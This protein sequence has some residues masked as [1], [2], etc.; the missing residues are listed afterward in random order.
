M[1]EDRLGER[2]LT[3]SKFGG[4][5]IEF[6]SLHGDVLTS[7]GGYIR[8][9]VG[10]ADLGGGGFVQWRIQDFREGGGARIRFY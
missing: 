10:G 8:F 5:K 6:C 2:C 7:T 1:T 9:S 3:H 4:R